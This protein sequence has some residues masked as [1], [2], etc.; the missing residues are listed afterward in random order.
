MS[1]DKIW[2]AI[3][4]EVESE[5]RAEAALAD[6]LRSTVL[7]HASLAEALAFLL[8]RKLGNAV[9]AADSLMVRFEEALAD[10]PDITAAVRADI[11]AVCSRD[12][13]VD[14]YHIPLLYLKGFHAL[15]AYRI[16]HWMWNNGH[17]GLA[18]YL[19]SRT[20]E[21][22]GVD[23]HPAAR[24]GRGILIDHATSVVIGETAVVEDEVSMLHEVT[25]GGTGKEAGDRHPK[26]RR[27][28]LIGA[29]VKVLGNVEIGAGAKIGAGSLV[30]TDIPAHAT[31]V[32]VPAEVVGHPAADEPALEMDQRLGPSGDRDGD[33]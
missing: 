18:R 10:D 30:L 32:G 33:A 12:P 21:V 5:I 17:R 16:A 9:L 26:V 13:A 31:A 8:A 24:I 6:F 27:G 11:E 1:E 20:S 4:R 7:D 23:I 3:R 28:V 22:F 19:Q 2:T 29:G 14:A 15:Q 25:L